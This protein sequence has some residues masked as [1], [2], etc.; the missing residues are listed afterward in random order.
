MLSEDKA[1]G[2]HMPLSLTEA[3]RYILVGGCLGIGWAIGVHVVS[4]LL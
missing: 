3:F 2:K 1:K 4:R